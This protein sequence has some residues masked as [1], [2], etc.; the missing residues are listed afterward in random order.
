MHRKQKNISLKAGSLLVALLLIL[1]FTQLAFSPSG[2]WAEIPEPTEEPLSEPPPVEL[3]ADLETYFSE[4]GRTAYNVNN[5]LVLVADNDPAMRG[6]KIPAD[7]ELLSKTRTASFT[8]TYVEAGETDKW[9]QTC[10]TFPNDAKTSFNYAAAIWASTINSN[11]PITI[12][13]CWADLGGSS[14]LGYSGGGTLHGNFTGAPLT[15]TWYSASLAN[16]LYGSDLD[17]TNEDMHVTYNT[18]FSW[19]YG[20]DANPPAG[21]YDLVTVATHEIAHGLNFSGSATTNGVNGSYGYGTVYPNVYDTFMRDGSETPLTSYTNPSAALHTL[22]TSQNLWF[23]GTNAMAAN[24]SSRVKM[25]APATWAPGSSYSH[26][27][28][29]TFAGTINSMMVYSISSGSANHDTGPVTRG[30]LQD[31]GW[32]PH[33]TTYFYNFLPMILR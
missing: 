27:D 8:I 26:L 10:L 25:Y 7:P 18:N 30:L 12:K 11:V 24:G 28:Y 19:Y 29:N 15:Y 32:A 21:T 3:P 20:L 33:V 4:D 13:A 23:H 6:I 14:T 1:V 9:G 31:L 5:T 22:L 17:P 16:S 2:V